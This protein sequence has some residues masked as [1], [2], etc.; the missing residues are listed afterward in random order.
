M[1]PEMP[2]PGTTVR[3]TSRGMSPA[4]AWRV[5]ISIILLCAAAL[6]AIF[7]PFSKVLSGI[8]MALVVFGGFAFNLVPLCQPGR[9]GRDL[10]KAGIIIVV[11]FFVI[12][13]LAIGS[14][15]LYGLY[16]QAAR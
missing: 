3:P 6:I 13:F 4:T 12:F 15:H 1:S 16:L 8:G 10:V 9:P 5:E 11:I 7:Q 14:A 2:H